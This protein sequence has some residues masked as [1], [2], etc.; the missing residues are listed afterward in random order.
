MN[1][2]E[3]M[4]SGASTGRSREDIWGKA[5]SAINRHR[6]LDKSFVYRR[7]PPSPQLAAPRPACDFHIFRAA[8]FLSRTGRVTPIAATMK[9]SVP[10]HVLVPLI[11]ASALF[12]QQI[13]T[14]SLATSLPAIADAFG[15]T[16]VRTHVVLTAY[17]F[18]LAAFIPLSGW[19]ADRFG[20]KLV[21]CVAIATFTV[22]SMLCGMTSSFNALIL[23][24]IVQGMGGA[25][26]L[27]VGR[28]ILLRSV[29]RAEL[30]R[31]LALMSMPA[32]IGPIVGPILGGF[33]T[34]YASWRWVFWI[35]LPFG[36]VGIVL[37]V[38]FIDN[39]RE[40]VRRKFD[41][42]GVTL[43]SLGL[44]SLLF[45][46][47]GATSQ[48]MPDALAIPCVVVGAAALGAYVLHARRQPEPV[49]NLALFRNRTFRSSI[50]GGSIFRVAI[51]TMPFL[52]PLLFQ[53]M[54]KYPAFESGTVTFMAAAGAFGI[55]TIATRILARVG[56]RSLLV[57]CS[58]I[59]AAFT[60]V[61]AIFRPGMSI[62]FI[63]VILFLGGVFRSLVQIAVNAL[64]YAELGPAQ[65]SDG[66][67]ISTIAQRL[68]QSGG[69]ATAA[70]V[71]HIASGNGG[72]SFRGFE[73]AFGTAGVL[74]LVAALLFSRFDA[75][76]GT[77][78]AGRPP[79]RARPEGSDG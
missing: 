16:T 28:L 72:L 50:V 73:F 11:V 30:V 70:F 14:T 3:A 47:D 35:N 13:D 79:P 76:A 78:L 6:N 2:A 36:I 37:T 15:E 41:T 48:S 10:R 8:L 42:T 65:I 9:T 34:T 64:A 39:V 32:L 49:I 24:R 22:S 46:I 69:V 21:F 43:C 44:S 59:A 1:I 63:L 23:G 40:T 62:V 56:F 55:R 4:V 18:S 33:L 38:L 53:E 25:M 51:N 29:E 77:D 75:D 52:L 68:S 71:L 61:C 57:N 27:P 17:L 60:A 58:V 19:I 20:A 54:F 74:A 26:M 45:G 67:T 12:L 7:I 31:A 5:R 66:T